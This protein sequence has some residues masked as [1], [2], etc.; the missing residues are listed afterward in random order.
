MNVCMCL[1]FCSLSFLSPSLC[2][3]PP[4]FYLSSQNNIPVFCPALTDG[5][6]GDMMYIHSYK[7]PGLIVDIAQGKPLLLLA[8]LNCLVSIQWN[9]QTHSTVLFTSL[10]H[11]WA[12]RASSPSH[13]TE[14]FL[15]VVVLAKQNTE[16]PFCYISVILHL[17]TGAIPS[18]PLAHNALL[19]GGVCFIELWE[20]VHYPSICNYISP[21]LSTCATHVL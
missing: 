15:Q 20:S 10:C 13:I 16:Y 9:L 8:I 19:I 7:N 4:L 3:T 18:L 12:G 1:H 21:G 6:I 11:N 5:S 14:K 17:C 2:V